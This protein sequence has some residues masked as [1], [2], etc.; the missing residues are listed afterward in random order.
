MPAFY[1]AKNKGCGCVTAA[2]VD[3]PQYAKETAK[4]VAE[5]IKEGRIVEHITAET[6]RVQR[7]HHK[8]KP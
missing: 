5:W 1:I 4:D 3:E 2:C 7:C 8:A 6:V